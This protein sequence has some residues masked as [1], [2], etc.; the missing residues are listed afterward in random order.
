MIERRPLKFDAIVAALILVGVFLLI[1]FVT[2]ASLR[3]VA[4]IT[5]EAAQISA[6][7]LRDRLPV[8]GRGDE[9]DRRAMHAHCA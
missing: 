6:R 8:A 9:L 5:K 7:N 4:V 1:W 2:T 3:P